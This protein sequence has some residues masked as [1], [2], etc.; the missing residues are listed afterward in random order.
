MKIGLFDHFE[1]S[2]DRSLA[3]QFDERLSFAAA[4]D[5]AGFYALHIAEHHSTPLNMVPAPGVWLAA[6]ARATKRMRLG[7]L[8]YLLPLRSPVQIAEEI[9]MLDHMSGGRLDVGIGRGVSPYEIAYHKVDFEKSREIFLDA[10]GCLRAALASDMFDYEGPYYHYA[11]V[12]MPLRPLQAPYPP[13]WYGSSG[14]EGSA[15]SG[16]EGMNFVTNGPTARAKENI[17]AFRAALARRGS[18][19]RPKPEFEGGAAIGVLRHVVVADT[20]AEARRIAKP[21]LEFHAKSLNWLRQLHGGKAAVFQANVHRGESFESWEAMEMTIAGAPDAVAS[22]LEAQATAMGINYL[23]VYL[24]FGTMRLADALRSMRLFADEVMPR[25]T[26]AN[27][28]A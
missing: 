4:A 15:W 9:C 24:F 12:P 11:K 13:F 14:A 17:D 2:P 22:K 8:V 19:A 25:L 10:Y 28:A 3:A 1:R 26:C 16:G 23:I 7:P 18:A 5:E 20:D 21:A 6:V 27:A